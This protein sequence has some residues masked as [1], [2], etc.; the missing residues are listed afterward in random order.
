MTHRFLDPPREEI[1]EALKSLRYSVFE[2]SK[3]VST[4]TFFFAEEP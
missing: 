1:F 3:L 4:K 2:A